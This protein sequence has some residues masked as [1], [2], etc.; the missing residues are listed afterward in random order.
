MLILVAGVGNVLK[1]DDGFGIRALRAFNFMPPAGDVHCLET[2]IGG[3]HLVQELMRGYDAVILFDAV[4][5]GD[6]PGQVTV[7]EPILPAMDELSGTERHDYFSETH[8]AKPIRALTFAREVGVLPAI[9]R[10][11]GCQIESTDSFCLDLSPAV[12]A[13]V[14][15]AVRA[16]MTLIAGLSGNVAP[17]G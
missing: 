3:M 12:E 6:R 1:G 10:V 4:D 17:I 9:V 14:P 15:E 7:L 2:G 11:I 8:Y 16:A 13:A 5:R